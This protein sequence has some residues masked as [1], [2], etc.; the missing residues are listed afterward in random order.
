MSTITIFLILASAALGMAC[1][2]LVVIVVRFAY[3]WTDCLKQEDRYE[4]S[5]GSIKKEYNQNSGKS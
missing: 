3:W 5:D 4:Q 1:I 2:P